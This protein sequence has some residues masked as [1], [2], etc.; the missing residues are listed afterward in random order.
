MLLIALSRK[1][2]TPALRLITLLL[3]LSL[4]TSA[5]PLTPLAIL[6]LAQDGVAV[7]PTQ[8]QPERKAVLAT[9]TKPGKLLPDLDTERRKEHKK[10]EKRPEQPPTKCGYRDYECQ[11]KKVGL[12]HSS[13]QAAELRSLLADNSTTQR[14]LDAYAL[15]T[16]TTDA[17]IGKPSTRAAASPVV[18]VQSG[19][20]S[21]DIL[22]ARIDP[23][24]RVGLPG[25]D[26]LSGNYNW[27]LPLV[28]VAGRA[29]LDFGL[30]LSYNSLMWLKVNP[31]TMPTMLFDPDAGNPSPGWRLGFPE[32]QG[33]YSDTGSG[34]NAYLLIMPSGQRIILRQVG[35]TSV[36]ES[37]DSSYLQLNVDSTSQLTLRVPGGTTLTLTSM[38]NPTPA[39]RCTQIKDANGNYIS[40]TYTTNGRLSTVTDTLGRVFNFSYYTDN[41]HIKEITQSWNGTTHSWAY[42]YYTTLTYGTNF[43]SIPVVGPANGSQYDVLHAVVLNDGGV[44]YFYYNGYG[45]MNA[46]YRRGADNTQLAVK[47]IVD[48]SGGVMSDAP[49]MFS[50]SD[51][52]F[53]WNAGWVITAGFDIN[54]DRVN[55]SGE[56]WGSFTAADGTVTKEYF[57]SSGWQHGLTLRTENWAGSVKKKWTTATYTQDNTSV[58]YQTNPRVTETNI[59]DDA[60]GDGTADNRRR[61]TISYRQVTLPNGTLFTAPQD[62]SEYKADATTVLRTSRTEYL[63][64][65]NYLSAHLLGLPRF[66]YLY[67]GTTS[68]TLMAKSEVI[69]DNRSRI[70]AL[71]PAAVQMDSSY[72]NPNSY[73]R[74][75]A[76][77]TRRYN[78]T[79]N[80]YVE[81]TITYNTA[82]AVT[83]T[84][85]PLGHS[86]QISYTDSFSDNVNRNTYAYPTTVTDADNYSSTMKYD[87]SHGGVTKTTNPKGAAVNTT[88]DWAGRVSQVT[89]AVNGAYTRYVYANSHNEIQSFTTVN[90]VS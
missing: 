12:Y 27:S 85:D 44:R 47:S 15:N 59:Y 33:S 29:G 53:D 18:P 48:G 14:T 51:W 69:Y 57:A 84:A 7:T 49:R 87:F 35:T 31:T 54:P 52:A 78:V 73:Y 62:V 43:G 65:T 40:A 39:Y 22:A 81:S 90:N 71:S 45:L 41:F 55:G 1:L 6:N 63:E 70:V 19:L 21:S 20:N 60:N 16:T 64:D 80:S 30:G 8:E 28:S 17:G 50:M 86:S 42:F 76:T 46:T 79:D 10:P 37:G 38:T 77:S 25:V 36:Y 9:H 26:L 3:C 83:A 72:N 75:L 23:R 32:V 4:A 56:R 58:S 89:N 88:Y 13:P 82:G 11:R 2:S 24:N 61:T 68:G 66:S 5:S 67:D 34:R 74:G